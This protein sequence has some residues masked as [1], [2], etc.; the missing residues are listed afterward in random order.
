L[1]LVSLRI[2][3]L[4]LPSAN[5]RAT[6]SVKLV[7]QVGVGVVAAGVAKAHAGMQ[8]TSLFSHIFS[9][10][11][12][13]TH[14]VATTQQIIS[15]SPAMMAA[16]ALPAGPASSTPACRGSWACRKRSSAW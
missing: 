14:I 3:I 6:V 2:I 16:P 7:S 8:P 13:H 4:L 5:I 10:F 1:L 11:H 12:A 9:T 15:S